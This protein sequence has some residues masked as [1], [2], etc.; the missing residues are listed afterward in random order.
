MKRKG[1]RQSHLLA[2]LLPALLVLSSLALGGC[3]GDGGRPLVLAATSDLQGFGILEAWIEDFQARTGSRV[4]LLT[5]SDAEG[6]EMAVHGECDLL[7]LHVPEEEERLE[8]NGYL[9]FRLEVMRDS[10]LLVGPPDDPAGVREAGSPEEALERIATSGRV[11]LV[12]SDESGTAS[13]IFFLLSGMQ[14]GE[15]TDWVRVVEGDMEQVL[16]QASREGA[17]TLADSSTFLRLAPD[18]ESEPLFGMNGELPNPY[19]VMAVGTLVYPDTD[20]EGARCFADYLLSEE[21]RK[22]MEKGDWSPPE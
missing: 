16:A 10:Y 15:T 9:E 8:R 13:R 1:F 6:L 11:F 3:E 14:A 2:A 17:Y 7:L 19:H 22:Y 4:E 20:A 5:V 12:R 18:L 21:A